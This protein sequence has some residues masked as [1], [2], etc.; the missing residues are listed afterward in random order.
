MLASYVSA[1]LLRRGNAAR[2]F[3]IPIAPDAT[4][5]EAEE[6]GRSF[7]VGSGTWRIVD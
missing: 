6:A 4:G 2:L 7:V 3:A 5:E 1:S